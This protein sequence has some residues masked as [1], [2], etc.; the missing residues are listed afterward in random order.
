MFGAVYID[1]G[2]GEGRKAVLRILDPIF[3]LLQRADHGDIF[4]KHPK[5]RFIAQND[6]DIADG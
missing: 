6:P 3:D 1:G 4:I 5:V 2:F